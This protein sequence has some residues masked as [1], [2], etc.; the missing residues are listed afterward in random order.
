MSVLQAGSIWCGLAFALL[1]RFGLLPAS[2]ADGVVA[3]AWLA[4]AYFC[5]SLFNVVNTLIMSA[6]RADSVA[7]GR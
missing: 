7:G 4:P 6:G 1:R 2:F 5:F 3:L